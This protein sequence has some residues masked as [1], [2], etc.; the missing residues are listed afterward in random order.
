MECRSYFMVFKKTFSRGFSLVEVIVVISVMTLV[1][2]GLFASF[3]YSLKLIAQSKAKITALALMTDRLEY[4]RS[5]PYDSIGT[6]LGIPAGVIP[7]NRTVTLNGVDFA[8]RVLVE[9]VDDPADGTGL[10]DSNGIISDYKR[11]KVEYSW[12]ISGVTNSFSTASTIVPRSIETSAGGGTLR[13]NIFDAAVQPLSGISVRLLNVTTTSTIDVTR[14]TDASGTALFT[15]AP[16]AANYQIF[17]FAPGYSSEQTY[18][19]TTSLP[20]PITL[21]VAVLESDVSTMNFQIDRLSDTKLVFVRDQ[22]IAS[23]TETFADFSGIIASSGVAISGGELHLADVL[24]VY[25]NTGEVWLTPVTPSPN[26]AWGVAE[27]SAVLMATTD[28]RVQFYTSTSASDLIP[29]S[30]LPG[31]ASGLSG[32]YIDLRTLSASTYPTLYA[33]VI[34][35]TSNTALT[36]QVE[37]LR[38]S[39]VDART[40]MSGATIEIESAKSIGTLLDAT[41]VP[42]FSL[43]TTTNSFGEVTLS[44]I[45]WGEYR[46]NQT[47]GRTVSEACTAS[48]FSVEPDSSDEVILVTAPYSTHN[49]RVVVKNGMGEA[50]IGATVDLAR[51]GSDTDTTGWC[52]QTFFPSLVS[53]SDYVLTVSDSGYSTVVI[54]PFTVLNSQVQEVILVP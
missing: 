1:F 44:D 14:S 42:K 2:G 27:F 3:E 51:T 16:A 28:A 38:L 49:L 30:D 26:I 35:S 19:A 20:N 41:V 23:V 31:N 5:L 52:G 50:I 37:E 46:F 33:K 24:G 48:P 34:L 36:P 9:Y 13:V 32:E 53:A 21:P 6:L 17:V 11:L 40:L 45:E 47:G 12:T 54:D 22:T 7:Q 10:L 4:L 39:Y 29:D 15:G 43:S 18:Q 25:G 8:E